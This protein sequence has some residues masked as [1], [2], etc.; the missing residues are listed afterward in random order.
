MV[1]IQVASTPFAAPAAMPA[2]GAMPS[3]RD[4]ERGSNPLERLN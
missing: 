1:T 3:C 4:G 2:L